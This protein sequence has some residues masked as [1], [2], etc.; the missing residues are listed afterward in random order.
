MLQLQ[1]QASLTTD[2]QACFLKVW[3][4]RVGS[5]HTGTCCPAAPGSRRAPSRSLCDTLRG[6]MPSQ[7]FT[8]PRHCNNTH[9]HHDT[10]HIQAHGGVRTQWCIDIMKTSKCRNQGIHLINQCACV[11]VCVCVCVRVCV[12]V[13]VCVCMCVCVCVCVCWREKGNPWFKGAF[14]SDSEA[15]VAL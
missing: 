3:P 4:Q 15:V 11:C 2:Q 13:C 9:T 8:Q 14:G 1:I 6:E 12:C 10:R 5:P 7:H